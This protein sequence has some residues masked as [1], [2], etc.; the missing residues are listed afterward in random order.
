MCGVFG[1]VAKGDN[2]P[3]LKR[4]ERIA[5]A[6]QKRGPHAFGF[7][8]IDGAGRL[9]MFKQTGR[10]SDALGLLTM[11]SDARMLIGHCRYAT[12]GDPR[13]NINNHPHP[14]DGGWFVHNGVIPSYQRLLGEYDLAP[15]SRCDSEVIGL[16]YETLDGPPLDCLIEACQTATE[17]PLVV[18]ALWKNPS[19]LIALRAGN[20]LHLGET[21]KSWYF[22]SLPD[23]LPDPFMLR[24]GTALEFTR[25][26]NQAEMTAYDACQGAHVSP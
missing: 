10:L 16:L 24:D 22:A 9:R 7:S 25:A 12:D 21:R 20:P 1:F 11:V 26:H 5:L 15:V 18:L 3:D 4:L 19:R 23:H 2:A 13:Y 8:W 6:T 14:I 17:N